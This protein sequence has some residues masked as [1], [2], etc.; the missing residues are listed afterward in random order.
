MTVRRY[1]ERK[2]WPLIGAEARLTLTSEDHR[3]RAID[4]ELILTGALD[5][6]QRER[7]R[8]VSKACPV[9]RALAPG[10]PITLR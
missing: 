5:D 2:Q 1:A 10:L 8:E 7:L 4:V 6:A 9:S 3:F